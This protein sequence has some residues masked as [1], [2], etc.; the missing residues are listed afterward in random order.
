VKHL[1]L[2]LSA[3]S[4]METS[5]TVKARLEAVLP[6]ARQLMNIGG[7]PGAAIAIID[8]GELIHSEYI[9]FHNVHQQLPVN[10]ATIFPCASLTKAVV[11]AAVGLCVEDGKFSW[12]TP[13]KDILPDFRT[14]SEILHHHMTPVDCLSHRAGMQSS[15]Y[16][17]GSMNNVLISKR[18]SMN[19]INDLKQVKPFRNEYL[20]NNLGYEVAA[21]I[22]E[23]TTEEPW[24][25]IVHSRI[26]QPLGMTRTGT[27]AYFDTGDNVAKAYAALD[28]ATVV[29]VVPMLSGDD[30]VGGPGSAMRSCIR[31]LVQLYTA[32]LEA[33]AHQFEN[34]VT[35]TPN[36]P[37]KQVP[38]LFSAKIAM[39]QISLHE[40]SYALGWAR[41]QTPGPMG[42]IGLNPDLLSPKP[43]P[44]IA[45]GHPSELILYH[46]GSMPGNLAAVNLVPSRK[47]AV[48]VLTNSLALNDTA[49]WLGQLYLE[50]Y[51]GVADSNDFV[52]LSKESAEAA[53]KWHPKVVSELLKDQIP[54]TTHRDLPECTG[55]YHNDARTVMIKIFT[56]GG[57]GETSLKLA[58]QGLD[59]EIF[60][61]THYQHD[62]FTWLMTRNEFARRG[63][64]TNYDANH[65]KICFGGEE[66]EGPVAFFTWWHDKYLHE[67]ER[68]TKSTAVDGLGRQE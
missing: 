63:R 47:G 25:R 67:P 41:V 45:R 5:T 52:A 2:R 13:V 7:T 60:P 4:N 3:S 44:E 55:T 66:P 50:T 14:R 33:G 40:T 6:H 19:F 68:F 59:S 21:H 31:D 24:E 46:Q 36:S 29:E 16:W 56:E 65:F 20:Y 53:L 8:N 32:F 43:A 26:Y 58:F 22:L 64:F 15:N 48:I 42:A 57:G 18:N 37:L 10:D 51:L 54:G 35:S 30:T 28:D 61:L 39:N 12:D 23:K 9:G 11:S 1:E 27:H 34:R 62:E 17:L 38:F 49:D